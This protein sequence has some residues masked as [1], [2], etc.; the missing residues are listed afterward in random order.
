MIATCDKVDLRSLA[1]L[2]G[3]DARTCDA[4]VVLFPPTEVHLITGKSAGMTQLGKADDP[5]L[6]YSFARSTAATDRRR[7]DYLRRHPCSKDTHWWHHIS[8]QTNRGPDPC[9]RCDYHRKR[10]VR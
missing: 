2:W 3:D 10:A 7:S 5:M 6:P 9:H 8:H 4:M 1:I